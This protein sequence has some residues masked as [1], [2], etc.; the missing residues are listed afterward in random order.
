MFRRSSTGFTL[1][2][3]LLVVVIMG[4]LATVAVPSFMRSKE[5]AQSAAAMAHLRAIHNDQTMYRFQNNRYGRLSEINASAE[6]SLGK[7]VG[8]TLRRGEFIFVMLPTPTNATLR[9]GYQVIAY[10]VKGGRVAS[11]YQIAE[12]GEIHTVLP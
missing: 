7:T 1:V 8:S 3:L 4:L 10:R 5:A 2:E 6:G 12:D 11:Q 9:S